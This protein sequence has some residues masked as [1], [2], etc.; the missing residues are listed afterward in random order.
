MRWDIFCKV[1]DNF[2]DAGVCWRLAGQ[3]AR[4]H[5][6]RVR[7][8]VDRPD[9]LLPLLPAGADICRNAAA[10]SPPGLPEIRHW[11]E[12]VPAQAFAPPADVVLEAFA[13]ALPE[14]CL[15]AMLAR[16]RPP[17]WVNLEYLSAEAW[18]EACHA[19]PSPHPRLPL[20]KHFFFPGF[21]AKTGGL[22]REKT[23]FA[24][25][26]AFYAHAGQEKLLAAL[27]VEMRPK[28]LLVS[29]FCYANAPLRA[30]FAAWRQESAESAPLLCLLP[31]GQ[32]L[33]ATRKILGGDGPWQL[34]A[35]RIVP[36]PFL[37]QDDYDTLLW[38]CDLNFVRGEDS[39]IRAQWA[40]KPFVWQPYPQED[41]AHL[42]KLA[43]FQ[44]RYTASLDPRARKILETFWQDW[45]QPENACDE[46]LA[47]HWQALRQILPGLER[48]GEAWAQ[49]LGAQ[50]DLA[51]ALV[52]FCQSRV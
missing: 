23:L 45:N 29:L 27:G 40:A 20:A 32:P 2:G 17:C 43:A 34:G 25:R 38:A 41:A 16:P 13:C 6:Q 18:V 22:L 3:L 14:A 33:A 39:F 5:G 7:L 31:P 46:R 26:A 8:W 52:R 44:E 49:H 48:H 51:T 36:I 28:T 11:R 21:T 19:L 12:D 35:A 4:E 15:A 50:E 47:R 10:D 24:R 42:K 37:P 30:L 9:V 1:I